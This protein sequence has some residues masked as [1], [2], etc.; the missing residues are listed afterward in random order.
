MLHST[1]IPEVPR[2]TDFHY[3]A[4]Y[5]ALRKDN[6]ELLTL[7]K[8]EGSIPALPAQY[9][10][11]TYALEFAVQ[12]H[13]RGIVNDR[14]VE[15]H[16]NDAFFVLADDIH[17]EVEMSADCAIYIMGL[18]TQ[19][20]EMLNIQLAQ[21]QLAQV[22]IRPTWHLTDT[23]MA[24][25]LKYFELLRILI[26][27]NKT[28]EVVHLVRSLLYNLAEDYLSVYPQQTTALTRAE[29]ICGEYLSLV[30]MHCREQHRV[31]WYADRMHLSPKYL[32]NVVKQTLHTS[33]NTFI[34]R[35]LTRQ[36]KSLLSSTS[37]SVQEIADRLGF[38]N[39]S[40]FGT[41]F[42]RQ[43][44]LSPSGFKHTIR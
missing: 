41:F 27:A 43:A 28:N 39:Q 5:C 22:L 35:A 11:P 21:A 6:F 31:E 24:I 32:S 15:L 20:V 16:P 29:Q 10:P 9:T 12:G 1:H 26:E 7:A 14:V 37:L 13:T 44:G 42:K 4:W 3:F 38:Q 23:Q 34:D 33:P 8:I 25:V 30:E 36:A 19:F 18:S 2:L 17:K 40:H